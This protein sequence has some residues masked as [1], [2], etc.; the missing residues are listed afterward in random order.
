MSV[1]ESLCACISNRRGWWTR[2]DGVCALCRCRVNTKL[3]WALSEGV[4]TPA[5][6]SKASGRALGELAPDPAAPS[7]N[8][9]TLVEGED[10]SK[11]AMRVAGGMNQSTSPSTNVWAE[12]ILKALR[13]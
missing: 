8:A 11:S 13:G 12:G 4:V 7:E 10:H 1:Y 9:W 3:S 2:A 5:A 6:T